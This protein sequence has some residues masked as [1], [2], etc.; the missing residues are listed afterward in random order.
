MSAGQSQ[1]LNFT[2]GA[3]LMG[4]GAIFTTADNNTNITWALTGDAVDNSTAQSGSS[5]NSTTAGPTS[6]AVKSS[7][8]WTAAAVGGCVWITASLL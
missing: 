6:S 1:Q 7:N 8:L 4:L 2:L 5:S 3:E